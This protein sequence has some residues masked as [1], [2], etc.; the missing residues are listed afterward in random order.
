MDCVCCILM[1]S[2]CYIDQ[3]S[4]AMCCTGGILAA[5]LQ[6]ALLNNTASFDAALAHPD[7]APVLLE[8]PESYGKLPQK[9]QSSSCTSDLVTGIPLNSLVGYNLQETVLITMYPASDFLSHLL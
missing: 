1:F 8:P 4:L 5:F 7:L 2:M 6:A 3:K 9:S